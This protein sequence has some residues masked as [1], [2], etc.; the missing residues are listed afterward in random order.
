MPAPW[1]LR[2]TALVAL[3]TVPLLVAVLAR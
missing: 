1:R 2:D 3:A